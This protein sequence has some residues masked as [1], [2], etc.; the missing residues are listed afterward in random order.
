MTIIASQSTG[1]Y[2]GQF[3]VSADN[4][5]SQGD[6]SSSLVGMP[7]DRRW[8]EVRAGAPASPTTRG[9]P[10]GALS[11]LRQLVKQLPRECAYRNTVHLPSRR[12]RTHLAPSNCPVLRGA[13]CRAGGP[14]NYATN[15]M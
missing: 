10:K 9:G 2:P 11:D 4:G 7:S 5:W 13:G 12:L 3:N 1:S 14:M 8:L 6:L 15:G